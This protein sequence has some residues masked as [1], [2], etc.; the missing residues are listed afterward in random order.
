MQWDEKELDTQFTPNVYF[1][2]PNSDILAKALGVGVMNWSTVLVGPSLCHYQVKPWTLPPTQS[3]GFFLKQG[4]DHD[5]IVA[6]LFNVLMRKD[7]FLISLSV[8]LVKQIWKVLCI[9][10]KLSNFKP[11]TTISISSCTR[12]PV[13]ILTLWL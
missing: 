13:L 6:V 5:N 3:Q 12:C 4:Q 10:K 11:F 1:W 2:T 9:C 7:K 8:P